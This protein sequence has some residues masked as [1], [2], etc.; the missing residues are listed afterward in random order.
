MNGGIPGHA[1]ADQRGRA[2]ARSRT[3]EEQTRLDS[4]VYTKASF[5]R[6]IN[7][8]ANTRKALWGYTLQHLPKA[9]VRAQLGVRT[10][11][12]IRQNVSI[13]VNEQLPYAQ[14]RALRHW[15]TENASAKREP[16]PL[17]DI[18]QLLNEV[19]RPSMQLPE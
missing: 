8:L 2:A 15:A 12:S 1:H 18:N 4:C 19:I 16:F 6:R 14:L 5:I 3:D 11:D 17:M 9:A 7:G 13:I 10:G